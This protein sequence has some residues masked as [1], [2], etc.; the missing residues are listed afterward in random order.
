[1]IIDDSNDNP[2][3]VLHSVDGLSDYC[4]II[5]METIKRVTKISNQ[6]AELDWFSKIFMNFCWTITETFQLALQ[7]FL[8]ISEN[9]RQEESGPALY[10]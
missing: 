4:N 2:Y 7:N 9:L 3:T 1:M 6:D 10:F 5:L 8:L